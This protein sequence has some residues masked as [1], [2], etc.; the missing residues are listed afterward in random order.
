[1]ILPASLQAVLAAIR[2]IGRPHLV[3]GCVRDWLLGLKPKD[4]DVEVFGTSYEAL[5]R[6][7]APFGAT[8]LVGKSF[9]TI[10][11]RLGGH[12]YGFSLPRRESKTSAGH[13]GFA[14]EA[15][16]NLN[17]AEAAARRDFTINAIAWDPFAQVL[18]DPHGGER[19]LRSK[20]L[21]HTSAAFTEDPLRV[22]RGVQFA[23]RFSLSLAPETAA[24]SRTIVDTYK[25]LPVERVWG[26]W[27]KWAVKSVSPS[28][29]LGVLEDT[30]WL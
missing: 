16:P 4:F 6:V 17:V 5:A 25:E 24:L 3:G 28:R 8:D 12:E 23:A 14:V 15:D 1:M 18:I 9:A 20:I 10:K 11:L 2:G 21:R 19:D 22:L 30:G 29:G 27:D 26:E 7:L 13:R